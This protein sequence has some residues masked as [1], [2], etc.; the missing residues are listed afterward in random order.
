LASLAAC[1]CDLKTTVISD[2]CR[3]REEARDNTDKITTL[4]TTNE[5]AN[6]QRQLSDAKAE[7]SNF[8]QTRDLLSTLVECRP[9]APC[10]PCVSSSH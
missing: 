10:E 5:M 4:I 8:R 7:N 3:T 9:K 1:C 6:L 2:G